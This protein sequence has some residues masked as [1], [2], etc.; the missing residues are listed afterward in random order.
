MAAMGNSEKFE[1]SPTFSL[2]SA[3]AGMRN[4]EKFEFFPHRCTKV[5]GQLKKFNLWLF[6]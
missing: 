5:D 3:M 6:F 1:R 2:F 4:S